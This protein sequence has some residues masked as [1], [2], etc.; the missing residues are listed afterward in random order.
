M[1]SYILHELEKE[2]PS[3][4]TVHPA[5]GQ[6]MHS[7]EH[8]ATVGEQH[9]ALEGI[10]LITALTAKVGGKNLGGIRQEGHT[11]KYAPEIGKTGLRHTLVQTTQE[12]VIVPDALKSALRLSTIHLPRETNS[13]PSM[14][15]IKYAIGTDGSL[16]GVTFNDPRLPDRPTYWA[17]DTIE[18]NPIFHGISRYVRTILH[19]SFAILPHH[20][21]MYA[22][23]PSVPPIPY[24]PA[25]LEVYAPRRAR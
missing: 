8:A 2:Q 24:D 7:F 4:A 15:T 18:V 13:R 23:R 17:N 5:I 11:A 22:Q 14:T 12:R 19:T 20:A 1:G 6:Y 21:Y 16:E 3:D 9:S 10:I 25:E